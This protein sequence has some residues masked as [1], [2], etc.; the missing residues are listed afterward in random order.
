MHLLLYSA[1]IV[2]LFPDFI[3]VDDT[4]ERSKSN[5]DR[6]F[7]GSVFALLHTVIYSFSDISRQFTGQLTVSQDPNIC[8]HN[9]SQVSILSPRNTDNAKRRPPPLS[10]SSILS[11][12]PN[13]S[14]ATKIEIPTT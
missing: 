8:K 10:H 12:L 2:S 3:A 9:A 13:F 4:T 11:P 5:D 14:E 6:W 1:N 7:L